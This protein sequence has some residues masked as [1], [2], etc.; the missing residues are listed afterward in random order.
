MAPTPP[1]ITEKTTK[2]IEIRL[3]TVKIQYPNDS[4][5]QKVYFRLN[6]NLKIG[7]FENHKDGHSKNQKQ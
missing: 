7:P 2:E 4:G 6:R 5:Y 3:R 1:G